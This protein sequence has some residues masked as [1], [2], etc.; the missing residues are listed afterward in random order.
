MIVYL[1][2]K[3]GGTSV[4]GVVDSHHVHRSISGGGRNDSTLPATLDMSRGLFGGGEDTS[5]LANGVSA[6]L[7]PWGSFQ[8]F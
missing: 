5:G 6:N 3:N 1:F 8:G 4:Q 7:T 2:K